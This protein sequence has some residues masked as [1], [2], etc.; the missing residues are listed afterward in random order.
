MFGDTGFDRFLE[1]EFGFTGDFYTL[2]F[3]AIQQ[4]D[5]RNLDRMS[6]G[7]PQ[8]VW[9]YKLWSQEGPKALAA[10]VT[11][12]HPLLKRLADEEASERTQPYFPNSPPVGPDCICSACHLPIMTGVAIRLFVNV[13]GEV[14]GEY[15]Y[16]PE[17]AAGM[18]LVA[19][20]STDEPEDTEPTEGGGP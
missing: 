18:G 3:R 12:G 2:L 7:F 13:N 17:C 19:A 15:R 11:P 20:P 4:A 14:A 16:H 6:K 9:A 10:K 5:S 1:F 8:E